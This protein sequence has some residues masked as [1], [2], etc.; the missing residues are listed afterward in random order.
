MIILGVLALISLVAIVMGSRKEGF[1]AFPTSAVT[2]GKTNLTPNTVGNLDASSNQYQVYT[3][4]DDATL[5]PVI[6]TT[7]GFDASGAQTVDC[8]ASNIFP[9]NVYNIINS[10][11]VCSV[12]PDANGVADSAAFGP[13]DAN[14]RRYLKTEPS[15]ASTLR[16]GSGISC[17]Q[18]YKNIYG[19]NLILDTTANQYYKM[20]SD[21]ICKTTPD[22]AYYSGPVATAVGTITGGATYV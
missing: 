10:N 16:S 13:R 5:A 4:K 7:R 11:A 17:N 9:K 1:A 3:L 19:N 18:Q 8:T 20:A 21:P 12:T 15:L 14:G 6:T 2:T 22:D